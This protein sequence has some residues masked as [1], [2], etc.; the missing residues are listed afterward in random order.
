MFIHLQSES[1][2]SPSYKD[3]WLWQKDDRT[4]LFHLADL[5]AWKAL[6]KDRNDWVSWASQSEEDC[7]ATRVKILQN[8]KCVGMV[9]TGSDAQSQYGRKTHAEAIQ[10]RLGRPLCAKERFYSQP[11][12]SGF[13]CVVISPSKV[14]TVGHGFREPISSIHTIALDYK[15]SKSGQLPQ[16]RFANAKLINLKKRGHL[17]YAI[18]EIDEPLPEEYVLK[19][20]SSGEHNLRGKQVYGLGHPWGLPMKLSPDARVI[21]KRSAASMVTTWRTNLDMFQGSSGSGIFNAVDHNLEGIFLGGRTK[22]DILSS[23]D[24]CRKTAVG[25]KVSLSKEFFLDIN[26]ILKLIQVS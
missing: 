13:S 14:L 25:K 23:T 7:E 19:R 11:F 3:K 16:P 8:S 2:L 17:D 26:S 10:A 18:L 22:D 12:L 5:I 1:Q 9:L 15:M 21:A 24:G 4:D 20:I 6:L